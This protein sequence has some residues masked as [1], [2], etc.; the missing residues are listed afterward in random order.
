[1]S[2]PPTRL[3]VKDAP[4]DDPAGVTLLGTNEEGELVGI[5]VASLPSGGAAYDDTEIRQIAEDAEQTAAQAASQASTAASTASNAAQAAANAASDAAQAISDAATAIGSAGAAQDAANAAQSA[6]D[7]A[8]A[9]ADTADG[10]ADAASAAAATADG[11]AV[12]AQSAADAAQ[13]S[14]DGAAGAAATADG[15]A[16]SALDKVPTSFTIENGRYV[17]ILADGSKING[18][19]VPAG[20]PEVTPTLKA[21]IPNQYL[22]VGDPD[23]QIDLTLYFEDATSYEVSPVGEGVTISGSTMTISCAEWIPMT[24]FTVTAINGAQERSD[25]FFVIVAYEQESPTLTGGSLT[26]VNGN[27]VIDYPTA[28]GT[29]TPTVTV[30]RMERD[31]TDV[32]DEVVGD[33]IVTPAAGFYEIEFNASNG[34]N[35]DATVVRTLAVGTVPAVST[36]ASITSDGT[37]SGVVVALDVGA[38]TGDPAPAVESIEWILD[39]ALQSETGPSFDSTGLSGDL[40]ARVRWESTIGTVTS[41]SNTITIAAVANRAPVAPSV[42][43]QSLIVGEPYSLNAAF[44]DPD[45]DALT[46]T[47]AGTLPQGVTRT[48]AVFSGTPTTAESVSGTLTA[49]DGEFSVDLAVSWSVTADAGTALEYTPD[50][51]I[52]IIAQ[53]GAT[54]TFRVNFP[55]YHAGDYTVTNADFATGPVAVFD[56]VISGNPVPEEILTLEVPELWFGDI[57]HG[58]ISNPFQWYSGEDP[59]AGTENATQYMVQISDSGKPVTC[60]S[61]GTNTAGSR[62]SISNAINIVAAGQARDTFSAPDGT[63]LSA[64]VGESS[65][66]WDG[67][68][69]NIAQIDGGILRSATSN[70]TSF[71]KRNDLVGNDYSI[72]ARFRNTKASGQS[73]TIPAVRVSGLKTGIPATYDSANNRW[74]MY[75]VLNNVQQANLGQAN[76]TY[77][78][79]QEVEVEFKVVGNQIELIADGVLMFAATVPAGFE[80]GSPGIRAFGS[81]APNRGLMDYGVED[82][83]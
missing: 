27:L 11:K 49:S 52:N 19:L 77:A 24:D 43:A 56:P 54:T 35:P 36:P 76:A 53:D 78:E 47:F 33:E 58:D 28:T 48:G 4:V 30:P 34:V 65:Y 44:T 7:T 45:G 13:A 69:D 55:A 71:A 18:P 1:M 51:E 8:Q 29:P 82:L 5:P 66:D 46:Y 25:A 21:P 10:K 57:N 37:D 72:K 16:D 62:V 81:D 67:F 38:A 60:R 79:G 15:K 9:A 75:P 42:G 6:A 14:A 73:Y 74:R 32:L 20:T 68:G 26:F 39:G 50:A 63:P 3:N 70:N 80:T 41:T 17:V 12:A 59:I 31:D 23:E 61:T 83:S 22:T 64:Y 2:L 40:F